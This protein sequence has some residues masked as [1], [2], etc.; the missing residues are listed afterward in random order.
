MSETPSSSTT[1]KQGTWWARTCGGREVL[2]LALPLMISTASWAVMHFVD[3]MYLLWYSSDAMAAALPAGMLHFTILCF[4]LGIATY[5]N[6][7]VA[8][9]NGAGHHDRIGLAVWQGVRVGLLAMPLFLVAIP[10]APWL[11]SLVGHESKV[12]ELE[13]VYFQVLSVGAGGA[14]MS[15]AMSAFFT[16]RGQTRVVMA[17]D[18]SATLMNGVLDYLWIFGHLGFSEMGIEGAAWATVVSQ[19]F[20]AIVYWRLMMR[21]PYRQ[22]YGMVTGRRYDAALFRRLL[23]FG[24]PNGLQMLVEVSAFTLFVFLV[25]GISRDA[26]IT[27]TIALNVS[28]AT[29]V[30][31]LGL[32]VAVSTIVGRQLG[33]NRSDLAARATWTA[34]TLATAYTGVTAAFYLLVPDLFLIGF[35]HANNFEQLHATAVVLLRFVAAYCLLDAMNIVF[36]SAIKGAGDT[37]FILLTTIFSSTL[38]VSAVWT[39]LWLMGWG[40]YWCWIV[41]TVWIFLL[42]TIYCARF[43]HGGWRNMRV[44]ESELIE[45]ATCEPLSDAIATDSVTV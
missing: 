3:R 36:H 19:W 5:V 38:L 30:P 16:G 6:T 28:S 29:F 18:C 2:V 1:A 9:Y 34:M 42:G 37:R 31:L 12:M 27:T 11:F 14:V 4:P 25:G 35:A 22:R 24:G 41:I 17:V 10:F 45:S 44:I 23:R 33:R 32:G 43:L 26:M 15:A 8:Q 21:A 20:K 39:G 7:F 40:L 13:V